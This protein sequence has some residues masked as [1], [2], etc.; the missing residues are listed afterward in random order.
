MNLSSDR[1]PS[2][3]QSSMCAYIP[4]HS[5]AVLATLTLLPKLESNIDLFP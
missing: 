4:S 3:Y 5:F 1:K 2:A